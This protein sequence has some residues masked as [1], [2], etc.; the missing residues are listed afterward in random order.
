MTLPETLLYLI[1]A[2]AF[3]V[4]QDFGRVSQNRRGWP[5]PDVARG[6]MSGLNQ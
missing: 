3:Y 4:A 1:Y 6:I 2:I 5:Q